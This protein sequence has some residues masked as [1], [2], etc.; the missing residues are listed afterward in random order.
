M[1][2]G[3][4]VGGT[5][6][7]LGVLEG[8]GRPRGE[9]SVP[10]AGEKRLATI[11]DGI[12]SAARELAGGSP[13]GGVGVGMPGLIDRR[14]GRVD[15][16]P[17]LPVFNGCAL[18]D[19]LARRLALDPSLVVLENDAN[20][21]ALGEARLGAA[22]GER[23]ALVV[24]LGTGVGGGLILNGELFLGEGLAGEIGHVVVDPEGPPCG[25]GS[26]GCLET[27]ASATA[28]RR[29]AAALGLPEDLEQLALL[30]RA[31]DGRERA[32]LAAVGRDLGHGLAAAV[33]LLDVRAFVFAGG[34]AAALDTLVPGV[35][36]GLAEWAYGARVSSV[37][38]EPAALGPAA[39]WI[40]AALLPPP[41]A[42]P[43]RGPHRPT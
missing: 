11:L 40:G 26:R 10:V 13:F 25:C 29:R 12:V 17:N 31:R 6:V 9:R 32:L 33:C 2:V 5:T 3:I 18:R 7:K 4:D 24:T 15:E 16:S 21:A 27:F 28:A 1:R 8:A 38:L 20:A 35:R 30:A 41:V 37:R 22:R 36:R 42:P 43:A 34:F 39:G 14:A 23:H 19:E